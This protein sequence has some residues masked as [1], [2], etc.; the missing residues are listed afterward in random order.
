MPSPFD[1]YSFGSVDTAQ[2]PTN[3]SQD[4]VLR[5]L[6]LTSP[7]QTAYTTKSVQGGTDAGI[8][9]VNNGREAIGGGTQD[10]GVIAYKDSKGQAVLTNVARD[11]ITG[12]E[13]PIP[14]NKQVPALLKPPVNPTG[15]AIIARPDISNDLLSTLSKLRTAKNLGEANALYDSF[16][17][18]AIQQRTK[19]EQEAFQFAEKKLGIPQLEA[20]LMAARQAD[21]AD[22]MWYPGIGDSPI[23]QKA[24]VELN[25]ARTMADNEA[26]NFLNQNGTYRSLLATEKSAETEYTRIRT[27]N[28]RQE[29]SDFQKNLS[30]DLGREA[31][32]E[33]AENKLLDMYE[34]LSA[35]ALARINVLNAADLAGF[36]NITDDRQRKIKIANLVQQRAKDKNWQAAVNAESTDQLLNLSLTGNA[37]ARTLLLSEEAATMG[38]TTAQVEQQ[39]REAEARLGDAK[40]PAA[41]IGAKKGVDSR[42]LKRQTEEMNAILNSRDPNK[43]IEITNARLSL[44]REDLQNRKTQAFIHDVDSWG[45]IDP[46]LK[47]AVSRAKKTTGN[48]SIPNVLAAYL[49]NATDQER[50]IK[51]KEFVKLMD[52]AAIKHKNSVFGMP[53][54]SQ[55]K[56]IVVNMAIE[57]SWWRKAIGVANIALMASNPAQSGAMLVDYLGW[58]DQGRSNK[59]IAQ[60]RQNLAGEIK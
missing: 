52:N 13:M 54:T 31:K 39:L 47:D 58:S 37:V 45:S 42:E 14:S 12:R 30:K 60:R 46:L 17:Q 33:D 21:K 3:V 53:D 55:A 25:T 49:E 44:L 43:K 35:N 7:Q 6:N 26:K 41:V 8:D 50:I 15:E 28:D 34:G 40:L 57:Q 32:V 16:Q 27:F 22:A 36:Q 51:A 1:T 9:R 48:G 23:T 38:I 20:N 5:L 59:D 18:S 10:T 56:Q 24:L 19:V 29:L 2:N 11:P 4:D